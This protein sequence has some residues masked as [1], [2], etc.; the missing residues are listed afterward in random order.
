MPGHVRCRSHLRIGR[1]YIQWT[2][3]SYRATRN[4]R[5]KP[6]TKTTCVV[7]PFPIPDAPWP[8][9]LDTRERENDRDPWLRCVGHPRPNIGRSCP[10]EHFYSGP[11]GEKS[12]KQVVQSL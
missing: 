5:A 8:T 7:P 1:L 3:Q 4:E 2:E 9:P 12:E 10:L 11:E 6:G